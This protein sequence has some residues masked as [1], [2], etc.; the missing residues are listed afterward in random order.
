MKTLYVLRH[1]KAKRS[2]RSGTDHARRLN[3]S[4]RNAAVRIGSYMKEMNYVPDIIVSSSSARTMETSEGIDRLLDRRVSTM[5]EDSLYLADPDRLLRTCRTLDRAY[6]SALLIG[7]NP[8]MHKF[9]LSLIKTRK[10]PFVRKLT[11]SFP[12]C[13]LAVFRF[14]VERWSGISPESGELVDLVFPRELTDEGQ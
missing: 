6:A 7:H 13:A 1:A 10:N 9:A 11:K 3:T 2:H 14:D 4:G 12:T 5:A 8:G